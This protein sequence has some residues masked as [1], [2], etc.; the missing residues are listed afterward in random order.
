MSHHQKLIE[1]IIRKIEAKKDSYGSVL[2]KS[3]IVKHNDIWENSVTLILPLYKSDHYTPKDKLD[4][5]DLILFEELISLNKLTE[6][7]KKLPENGIVKVTLGGYE[8]QV[9]G[10]YFQNG[11][12]YDS[13]EEYLNVNWF[14][15]R[16]HYR[17][18]SRIQPK[19]PLV[20]KDLPLFP[21]FED[22]INQYMGIDM[23]RYSE[24]YGILVCLPKYGA[25]IEEVNIGSNETTIKV[26][27]K[28]TT[29]EN[30]I[31]KLY[32]KKGK[33]VKHADIEFKDDTGVAVI[34]FMPDQMYLTLISKIDNQVVDRRRYYSSWESLSKGVI[35][36]VPGYEIKEL[37]RHGESETVEFKQKIGKPEKIAETVVA[38]ANNRGGVILFGIGDSSDVIGLAKDKH[39]ETITNILR[40]HCNPQIKYEINQRQLEEKDIIIV[41]VEEGKDKPY[42]V[43][44]RGPYIRAHA[45]NRVMTRQEMDEIYKKKQSRYPSVY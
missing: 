22:A 12:K 9:N 33:E 25:R 17:G 29:I 26:Q 40:S 35:I 45:T 24:A 23:R 39:G 4:Y 6:L 18:R 34:G 28:E 7:I 21:D 16:Y 32:C 10:E 19:E 14:F 15:E 13:G 30:L 36:D 20:S 41:H 1:E 2:V 31:G 3:A 42:F 8:V 43:R 11:Y 37:I 38:F 27:P 5:G 44:E